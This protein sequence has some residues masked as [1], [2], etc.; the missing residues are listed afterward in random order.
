MQERKLPKAEGATLWECEEVVLRYLLEDGKVN[1]CLRLVEA[2]L[3]YMDE[4]D[5]GTKVPKPEEVESALKFEEGIGFLLANVWLHEEALQTTDLPLLV[6]VLKTI[7]KRWVAPGKYTG[8]QDKRLLGFAFRTLF[9]VGKCLDRVG[10]SRV[11]TE[12]LKQGL[13]NDIVAAFAALHGNVSDETLVNALTGL[14]TIVASEDF[15]T[16]RDAFLT[17]PE[18]VATLLTLP[19][20][21]LARYTDDTV[22]RRALRPLNDLCA[23]ARRKSK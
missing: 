7:L 10:E 12:V 22:R 15:Q 13:F 14:S 8:P 20:L 6:A 5:A 11:V 16:Q 19:D 1:L 4:V 18:T 23:Y 2:F 21:V 3:P 17:V 9:A